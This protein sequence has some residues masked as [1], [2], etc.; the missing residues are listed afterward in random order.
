MSCFYL[1]NLWLQ[2][3]HSRPQQEIH[4][5]LQ[6]HQCET[7]LLSLFQNWWRAQ[8]WSSHRRSDWRFHYQP[9]HSH[10]KSYHCQVQIYQSWQKSSWWLVHWLTPAAISAKKYFILLLWIPDIWIYYLIMTVWIKVWVVKGH[11]KFF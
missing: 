11:K 7:W 8:G 9:Q 1:L 10:R 3:H 6:S 2:S 5:Q 4:V